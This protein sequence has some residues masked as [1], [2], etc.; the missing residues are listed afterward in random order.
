MDFLCV[1]RAGHYE[2]SAVGNNWW[3]KWMMILIVSVVV[4][5]LL[6]SLKHYTSLLKEEGRS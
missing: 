3:V 6:R 2:F 4:T 1:L 5:L